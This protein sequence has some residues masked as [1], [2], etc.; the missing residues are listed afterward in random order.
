MQK[1]LSELL[2]REM[3]R[4]EFL[5]AIGLGIASVLGFG[6]ILRILSGKSLNTQQPQGY[7]YGRST[8]GGR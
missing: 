1:Q 4:Q 6:S 8:Y 5:A 7:G 3:T 2:S